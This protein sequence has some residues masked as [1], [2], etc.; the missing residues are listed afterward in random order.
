VHRK[1]IAARRDADTDAD[2]LYG[3]NRATFG[4]CDGNTN[5]NGRGN[6]H[7]ESLESAD[8]DPNEFTDIRLDGST[9]DFHAND[10]VYNGNSDD[11]ADDSAHQYSHRVANADAD[12]LADQSPHESADKPA[13]QSAD[14]SA[15]RPSAGCRGLLSSGRPLECGATC[16]DEDPLRQR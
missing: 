9:P 3:S 16:G 1:R 13:D 12:K 11:C 15:G 7:G 14:K 4:F 5:R 2:F 8:R 10:S 6:G